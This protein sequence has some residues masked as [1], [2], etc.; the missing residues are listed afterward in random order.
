MGR[1]KKDGETDF[2][3][4]QLG[5]IVRKVKKGKLASGHVTAESRGD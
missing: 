5:R 3:T 4:G 1:V 2:L